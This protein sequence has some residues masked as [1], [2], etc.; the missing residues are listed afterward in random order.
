[1]D[2]DII[3]PPGKNIAVLRDGSVLPVGPRG[4]SPSEIVGQL[5]DVVARKYTGNNPA[6]QGMSLLEAAMLS[7]AMKAADGDLD[8]LNKIWDRL[9][10]KPLQQTIQ[11][12]GTLQEFLSQ[13]AA[14]DTDPL[15]D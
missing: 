8:A 11:A 13:I 15:G 9:L 4:L 6:L 3:Y 7:A 2:A 1:M 5:K 10:G 14:T 12:T